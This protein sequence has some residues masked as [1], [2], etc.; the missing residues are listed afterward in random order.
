L[1][2]LEG[3]VGLDESKSFVESD[4]SVVS[5]FLGHVDVHGPERSLLLLLF[6]LLLVEVGSLQSLDSLSLHVNVVLGD[7]AVH[8]CH[9]E[10][11]GDDVRLEF[12]VGRS[13]GR[14]EDLGVL[15]GGGVLAWED[16]G[17]SSHSDW[18]WK[19]FVQSVSHEVLQ[20]NLLDEV[21]RDISTANITRQ[22]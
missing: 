12:P 19:L 9:G 22:W 14:D 18:S 10:D 20:D 21:F 2:V 3:C 15:V 11:G 17:G 13:S 8:S 7:W 6:L 16:L 5:E 1:D 4:F